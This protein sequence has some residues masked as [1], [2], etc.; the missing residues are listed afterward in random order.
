[1]TFTLAAVILATLAIVA[2][3]AAFVVQVRRMLRGI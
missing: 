1:M 2:A 3:A